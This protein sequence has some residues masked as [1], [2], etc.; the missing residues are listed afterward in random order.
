MARSLTVFAPAKV[1]WYLAVL[2]K[3]AD[4]FHALET[5]F[6]RLPLADKLTL[7]D[8][9]RGIR[10]VTSARVPKGPKNLAYRAAA[11]LIE[12]SKKERGV[13]IRLEKRIPSEAGLGGGSSDAAAVLIGLNRLWRLGHSVSRL[14]RIGAK[15]GSD[16]P[17]FV[18]QSAY[19]VG[20]GR[21]EVIRPVA[22]KRRFWHVLVKPFF[23]ISTKE[24]YGEYAR[25]ARSRARFLTPPKGGVN[26]L[27]RFLR[28]TRQNTLPDGFFNSLELALNKRVTKISEIKTTLLEQGAA[29]A[30]LSGSGSTV[31]GVFWTEKE[32]RRAASAFRGKRGYRVFTV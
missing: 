15:I 21:G 23:G 27:V 11:L 28:N 22:S 20:R 26:I 5:L 14:S 10:L 4:G 8:R 17:F 9:P 25:L 1:N 13:E 3:R 32:A 30:L 6:V 2:G 19:A 12:E 18:S 16:V 29:A 31:F 24:A 7:T